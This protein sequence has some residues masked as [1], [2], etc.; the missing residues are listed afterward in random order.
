MHKNKTIRLP[1]K[2]ADSV[3]TRTKSS[4]GKQDTL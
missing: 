4:V 1:M 3:Q 2:G